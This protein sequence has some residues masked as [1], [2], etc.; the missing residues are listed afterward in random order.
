MHELDIKAVRV[1][2]VGPS[3]TPRFRFSGEIADRFMTYTIVRI[4]ASG[5]LEGAGGIDSEGIG[6]FDSTL[7][8]AL[9][10]LID[11][12][13]GRSALERN[14]IFRELLG[15]QTVA[16]PYGPSLIDI[17]LWDLVAQGA[18]F[19]LYQMLG[20]SRAKIPSYASSPVFDDPKDYVDYVEKVLDLG[21]TAVKFHTRGELDW[22]L[23]V[24]QAV[25]DQ[26]GSRSIRFM[27]DLE[28]KYDLER[29]LIMADELSRLEYAWLEAP[30]P[31]QDLEGYQRLRARTTVPILCSGNV[32]TDLPAI[33]EAIEMGCW[34]AVRTDPCVVGGITAA[35]KVMALAEA[36]GLS[37]EL[38][39]YGYP[40]SQ[41]AN[42]HLMLAYGNCSYF[43]QPV[44]VEH[45]NYAAKSPIFVDAQGHAHAPTAPGL[46]I[47]MDWE[48]IEADAFLTFEA[49]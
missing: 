23:A 42:L 6:A 40:L 12:L 21:Y 24:V 15:V 35:S 5:G 43:E 33:R 49:R 10:P 16:Q 7:A 38:Q 25:D 31:D 44:P 14:A 4:T 48:R 47:E 1:Y 18:G 39:S 3:L 22:D 11:R 28:E 17:A 32:I 45:F 36:N 37:T 19:P 9:Q 26:F 34:S 8:E 2:A 30:L 41:A 46:G 27:L 29:A 20:G 13:I